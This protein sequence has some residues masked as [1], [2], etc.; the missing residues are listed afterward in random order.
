MGAGGTLVPLTVIVAVAVAGMYGGML[1]L[2][3]V[4]VWLPDV[5][6]VTLK[7]C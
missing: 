6:S 4:N 1:T 2:V 3:I 7:V 5:L